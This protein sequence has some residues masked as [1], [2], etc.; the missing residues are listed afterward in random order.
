MFYIKCKTVKDTY[1][2]RL[3]PKERRRALCPYR[4]SLRP[5]GW[6]CEWKA[7]K[8]LAEIEQHFEESSR[9]NGTARI[10]VND[11]YEIVER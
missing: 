5:K 6:V 8:F 9:L 7:K 11:Y 2:N 1:V 3:S 4:L 10:D